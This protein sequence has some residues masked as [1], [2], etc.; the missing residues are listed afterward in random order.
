MSIESQ[1]AAFDWDSFRQQINAQV[2]ASGRQDVGIVGAEIYFPKEYVSQA[3]LEEYDGVGSGKYCIG[4]GQ[5]NM[6][7]CNNS[8]DIVSMSMTAVENLLTKYGI[9]RRDIGRIEVGT[10]TIADKSKS[11]KTFLMSQFN[12]AGCYDILGIDT[13]NACYGGTSAMLNAVNWIESSSWDGRYAI[14]VAGDIAVY[15]KGPARPTGGAGVVAMLIGPHAPISLETKQIASHMEHVYDF[16][17][18][19]MNSEYPVVDGKLSNDCYMRSIDSCYS[20]Y[21]DLFEKATKQSFSV[22][23]D[24]DFVI[25]HSPYTKLVEKS[26]ARLCI[27]DATSEQKSEL[28]QEFGEFEPTSIHKNRDLEKAVMALNK[29]KFQQSVS[30]GLKISQ[31]CGNMYT[32]SVYASLCSLIS[33]QD[34]KTDKRALVF[35]YGSGSAASMF[36]LR[37]NKGVDGM[38]KALDM[39]NRLEQRTKLTPEEYTQRLTEREKKYSAGVPTTTIQ[40]ES[41]KNMFPGTYYVKSIDPLGRRTYARTFS[42]SILRAMR[43]I[44]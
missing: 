17:K 19:H 39:K 2:L 23:N 10:E 12:E 8:E 6:A 4:L 26:F 5:K 34:A 24:S 1:G 16:Y 32:G 11:V 35:S 3:D 22:E 30:P 37:F 18:P 31:E 43:R 29:D 36:S 20:R 44:R 41:P 25:L 13:M 42:T 40:N 38:R 33:S 15:E 27:A 28:E 9:D 21:K 14:V 7:V